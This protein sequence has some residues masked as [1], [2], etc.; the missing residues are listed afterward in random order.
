MSWRLPGPAR[1]LHIS[2]N[3]HTPL[4]TAKLYLAGEEV[5][6]V[7]DTGA[8]ASVVEKHLACKLEIWKRAKKVKV[9]QGD[10]SFLGANFVVNT[11]FKVIDFF[12]VLGKFATD[13]EVLDI[14]NRD[15]LLG[16]S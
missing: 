8:S 13:T 10:G 11:T 5:E 1:G 2:R 15:M 7:V 14:G 16:L 6:A 9:K 4:L 3:R 12:L